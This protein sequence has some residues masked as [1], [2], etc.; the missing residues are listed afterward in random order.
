MV[1]YSSNKN[2]NV[3]ACIQSENDLKYCRGCS[4]A[5]EPLVGCHMASLYKYAKRPL[6]KCGWGQWQIEQTAKSCQLPP[7]WCVCACAWVAQMAPKMHGRVCSPASERCVCRFEGARCD[8]TSERTTTTTYLLSLL[9]PGIREAN[10][11]AEQN[12][13]L[14][15]T[16]ALAGAFLAP[17]KHTKLTGAPGRRKSCVHDDV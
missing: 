14:P 4:A 6:L 12:V 9:W 15:R 11:V 1:I 2:S 16:A 5:R 3:N 13:L 10:S 8:T 7:H 17:Q